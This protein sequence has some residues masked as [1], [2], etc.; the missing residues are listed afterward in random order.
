MPWLELVK[1]VPSSQQ[2][3][4]PK[5]CKNPLSVY[6]K[7]RIKKKRRKHVNVFLFCRHF[8]KK[9]QKKNCVTGS[10][11]TVLF[12][13]SLDKESCWQPIRTF[14]STACLLR[15]S[16]DRTMNEGAVWRGQPKAVR[17]LPATPSLSDPFTGHAKPISGE[18]FK[19]NH[20]TCPRR[21]SVG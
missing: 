13:P 2:S 8:S 11:E 21:S 17:C 9:Y 7:T 14:S 15:L 19:R 3:L 10:I 5:T 12:I 16:R 4:L 18:A 1:L 20:L 6:A